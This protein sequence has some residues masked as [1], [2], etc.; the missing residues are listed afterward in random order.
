MEYKDYYKILGVAKSATEKEIKAAYRKLAR[1]H[2]PDV[3]PGNKEA[4][5]R[6]KEINEAYEVIGNPEHR[7]KYDELGANWR[8]YQQAP[9]SG[10]EGPGG[11]GWRV[12]FGGPGGF[13]GVSEEE[14]GEM[15]GGGAFS[16]FF[17]T[18]FGGRPA[19]GR[20]QARSRRRAG[21][22]VEQEIELNLEEAYRG[23]LRRLSIKSDG[24]TRT[25]DVR[26]PA[27]VKDGSRVRIPGEGESGVEGGT[28][29]DLYLRIRLAPHERF[30]RRGNDLH[31]R[32]A[33]PVTTAALG[34]QAS[35][36]TLEG[37]P[38]RLKIPALTQGGQVFRV[39]D[40]GM[41]I[42]KRA[43]EHGDLYVAVDIEMPKALTPEQRAHYEAL[44]R[45]ER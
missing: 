42:M 36:P 40:K 15:L 7:K 45:L 6:F 34:G 4:E 18:F 10:A 17:Q 35:V 31:V 28:S 9:G 39:R 29:G 1:K 19:Q 41:P 32:V 14:L 22:D 20:G 16:E 30:E 5:A 26:I 25:V 24:H 11:Q 12:D 38:V 21:R 44:A 3:N 8:A 37:P 23:T 27:G 13:R 43:G 2:H 33:I